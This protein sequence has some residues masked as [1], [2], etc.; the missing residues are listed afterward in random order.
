MN[1][2]RSL[3]RRFGIRASKVSVRP[4]V[5]WHW[6]LLVLGM[7]LVVVCFIAWSTFDVGRQLAGFDIGLNAKRQEQLSL[8]V[9][10]LQAEVEELRRGQA[11]TER[12]LEMDSA[13]RQTLVQQVN[14]LNEE[15]ASLKEDLAFFQSL[16]VQEDQGAIT[17]SRFRVEPDA[18]PGEYR[19][20]LFVAQSRRN[21][22]KDFQGRLQLVVDAQRGSEALILTLPPE[23][24]L[25]SPSF[26]LSFRFYQRVEGMFTVPSGAVVKRVHARVI[27]QGASVPKSTITFNL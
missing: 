13:T 10:Q 27:E 4:H 1:P 20:H 14:S 25:D 26:K 17:I 12:Q 2:L 3:R 5:G 11:A 24:P 9:S 8:Q 23:G 21:G 7:V 6:R 16:M 18:L 22:K 15:N 19:Y